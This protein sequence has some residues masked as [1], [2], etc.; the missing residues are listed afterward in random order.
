MECD[1]VTTAISNEFGSMH[2]LDGKT[3]LPTAS[4][5]LPVYNQEP[6]IFE[7]ACNSILAQSFQDFELVIINDGSQRSDT[8]TFLNELVGRDARVRVLHEPHRGL[9]RSLNV[10][11]KSCR[12][13]FVCRQDSDDWSDRDR[14]QM[15]IDYLRAHSEL[16]VVGSWARLH[17]HDEKPLWIDQYPTD[18][19]AVA[20]AFSHKNPFCHGAICFRRSAAET[21]G[22]YREEFTTSQDYD[23]LWR[24]CDRYAGEN[25]PRVLYHR[26]F[27][28]TSISTNRAIDQARNRALARRLG[29]MRALRQ[30]EDLAQALREVDKDTCYKNVSALSTQA[31]YLLL[32]GDYWSSLKTHARSMLHTPWRPTPYVKLLRWV[33]YVLVPTLRPRLFGHHAGLTSG[34]LSASQASQAS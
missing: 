16:A 30:P 26:R 27:T 11:L 31:D 17:Q 2:G 6:T 4:V 10:G 28:A 1:M 13:E 21:I 12:G 34:E 8:I 15:Q 14:L 25:L 18:S 3:G 29:A 7:M 22:G 20:G 19:C 33:A 9:T 5:L 32:S 24:M 23:F